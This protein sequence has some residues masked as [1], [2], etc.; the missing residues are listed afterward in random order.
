MKIYQKS[1]VS[2]TF[3]HHDSAAVLIEALKKHRSMYAPGAITKI[4]LRIESS[5]FELTYDEF[6]AILR[7]AI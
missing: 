6:E 2:E 7:K 3:Y 5:V 1:G 4:E